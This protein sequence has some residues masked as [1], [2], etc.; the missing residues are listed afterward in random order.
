[1][2]KI[3]NAILLSAFVFTPLLSHAQNIDEELAKSSA[4]LQI[5]MANEYILG[6][7]KHVINSTFEGRKL[8]TEVGVM[9]SF[10]DSPDE[11]AVFLKLVERKNKNLDAYL[12]DKTGNPKL[13]NAYKRNFENNMR[14]IDPHYAGW[15]FMTGDAFR[16]TIAGRLAF[17]VYNSLNPLA[18]ESVFHRSDRVVNNV[19][20]AYEVYGF[21]YRTKYCTFSIIDG[22]YFIHEFYTK[23][24]VFEKE[25]P[26]TFEKLVKEDRDYI[27]SYNQNNYVSY[28]VLNEEVKAIKKETK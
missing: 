2:K 26:K 9:A 25:A 21:S 3:L 15:K 16:T 10:A 23:D 11:G 1:M 14:L 19:L 7:S 5:K 20:F 6:K 12:A 28:K 27:V 22:E 8:L 4:E 24:R 13:A 18:G 17:D